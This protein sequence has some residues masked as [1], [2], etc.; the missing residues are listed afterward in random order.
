MPGQDKVCVDLEAGA[1]VFEGSPSPLAA[2]YVLK[3][4]TDDETAPYLEP[5]EPHRALMELLA[6]TLGQSLIDAEGRARNFS[7]LAR[8]ARDVPLRKMVPHRSPDRLERMCGLIVEDFRNQV[9]PRR[10]TR[11]RAH[12]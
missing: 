10:K 5:L 9:T 2:I 6:N 11:A 8:L 4:R 3:T 1:H 7:F 12:V